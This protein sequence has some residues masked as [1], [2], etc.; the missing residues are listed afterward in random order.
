MV[1]R[2]FRYLGIALLLIGAVLLVNSF[3]ITGF[4]ILEGAGKTM[5]SVLGIVFV[6]VGIL[7]IQSRR[8]VE[9]E[10]ELVRYVE[11]IRT[12]SFNRSVRGHEG[13]AKNAI[14]KIGTGMG[15]EHKLITGDYS[16]RATKGARVVFAYNKNHTEATLKR[17]LSAH[18][19]DRRR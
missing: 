10:S 6:V 11:I 8:R 1:K 13:E 4:A 19:Y 12:K 15:G 9:K 7:L 5:G 16:I 18:E 2:E 14:A 3:G 17:Y